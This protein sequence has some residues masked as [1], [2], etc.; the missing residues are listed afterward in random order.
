L[1]DPIK[2]AGYRL[3]CKICQTRKNNA[4]RIINHSAAL[5]FC[6]GELICP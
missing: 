5:E 6:T 2:I 4:A 3:N 1:L